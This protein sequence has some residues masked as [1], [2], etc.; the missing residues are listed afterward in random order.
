MTTRRFA[1]AER[2]PATWRTIDA[3]PVHAPPVK[4]VATRRV[5]SQGEELSALRG[6]SFGF[7]WGGAGVFLFGA[8]RRAKVKQ[9]ERQIS[10]GDGADGT[11]P[12][13]A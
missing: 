7:I 9:R 6:V 13:A 5:R 12:D 1:S 10:M 4:R 2:A 8:W 11:R 3:P